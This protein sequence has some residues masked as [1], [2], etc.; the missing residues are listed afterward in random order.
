MAGTGLEPCGGAGCRGGGSLPGRSG[1]CWKAC[2]PARPRGR[3]PMSCR[4]LPAR[5]R[6]VPLSCGWCVPVCSRA[7]QR[8]CPGLRPGGRRNWRSPIRCTAWVIRCLR[9]QGS[10]TLSAC[11]RLARKKTPSPLP[12]AAC[13]CPACR[14]ARVRCW[15]RRWGALSI[16]SAAMRCMS[17]PP[18]VRTWPGSTTSPR[19][20]T[21]AGC[22]R[23]RAGFRCCWCAMHHRRTMRP[24]QIETRSLR[25]EQEPAGVCR[26]GLGTTGRRAGRGGGALCQRGGSAC[27]TRAAGRMPGRLFRRAHTPRR[28]RT[29]SRPGAG[30]G[31]H[32]AGAC[33]IAAAACLLGQPAAAH[34]AIGA[35]A[36]GCRPESRQKSRQQTRPQTRARPLSRCCGPY[37]QPQRGEKHA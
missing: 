27:R 34:R 16:P 22:W 37:R 11:G 32:G 18:R 1:R 8:C 6:L 15:S 31:G 30:G 3:L 20:T 9:Q 24:T 19:A 21:K 29:P 13:A 7:S 10:S 35:P 28:R 26:A 33:R 23:P 36:A 14:A 5:R 2:R 25:W 17:P 4:C 12:C